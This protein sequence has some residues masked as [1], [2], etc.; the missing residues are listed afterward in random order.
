MLM[1]ILDFGSQFA[2][3]WKIINITKNVTNTNYVINHYNS[4]TVIVK[5][6]PT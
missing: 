4:A 2:L 3:Q 1:T 5:L 6:T